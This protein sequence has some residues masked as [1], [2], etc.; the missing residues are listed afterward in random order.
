MLSVSRVAVTDTAACAVGPYANGYALRTY[1]A[2]LHNLAE[3]TVVY[4]GDADVTDA[5]GYPLAAGATAMVALKGGDEVWAVCA[6]GQT[7]EV[8]TLIGSERVD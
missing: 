3:Q 6:A 1:S 5:T 4:L 2:T 8:A 7:A